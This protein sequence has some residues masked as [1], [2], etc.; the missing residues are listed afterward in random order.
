MKWIW[1]NSCNWCIWIS[2]NIDR[3]SIRQCFIGAE[4]CRRSSL[5]C[6][7]C[8]G[9]AIK[10]SVEIDSSICA[11]CKESNHLPLTSPEFLT[12]LTRPLTRRINR[13]KHKVYSN[14]RS[15]EV[16]NLL[17]SH[18]PPNI[19]KAFPPSTK[20]QVPK[21]IKYASLAWV[22]TVQPTSNQEQPRLNSPLECTGGGGCRCWVFGRGCP[23]HCHVYRL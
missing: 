11:M 22:S 8:C 16:G 7:S 17:K 20:A 4:L 14:M 19:P 9:G 6:K 23:S 15:S 5:L 1:H 12:T 10:S 13:T 21:A 2:N 18:S 3:R